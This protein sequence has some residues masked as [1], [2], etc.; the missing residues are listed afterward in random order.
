[1]DYY[2]TKKIAEKA[3][4]QPKIQQIAGPF[5]TVTQLIEA[6]DTLLSHYERKYASKRFRARAAQGPAP[7]TRKPETGI[8]RWAAHRA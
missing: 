1:M 6:L 7:S 8:C 4:G 5:R 2:I 3:R